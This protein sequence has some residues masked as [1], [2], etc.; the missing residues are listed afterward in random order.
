MP[1]T[2]QLNGSAAETE[3]AFYDAMSRADLDALMN[4]WAEEEEIVCVHPG[5]GRVLGHGAIRASWAEIFKR[6]HA[7]IRP[8]QVHV[9]QNIMGAVH[10]IVEEANSRADDPHD[11]HILATNVYLKTPQGWRIVAHHASLAPG[12]APSQAPSSA[13]LH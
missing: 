8:V 1:V 6:G 9:M 12:K 7:R 10:N 13:I 11:L 4:L 5:G 3:A 2:N